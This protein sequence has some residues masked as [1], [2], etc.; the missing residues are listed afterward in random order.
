MFEDTGW[1]LFLFLFLKYELVLKDGVLWQ[2]C[3]GF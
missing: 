1:I 3:G 2:V